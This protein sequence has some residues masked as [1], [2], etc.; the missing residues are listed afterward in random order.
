MT[1]L[2]L[3]H[4]SIRVTATVWRLDAFYLAAYS[5][6]SEQMVPDALVAHVA[7]E[8]HHHHAEAPSTT[9]MSNTTGRNKRLVLLKS[10]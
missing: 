6:Q 7:R 2:P 10:T 1:A 8:R 3:R 9:A 4:L 5:T